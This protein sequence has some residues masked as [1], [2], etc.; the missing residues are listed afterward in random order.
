MGKIQ[1]PKMYPFLLGTPP[2]SI[3]VSQ[4]MGSLLPNAVLLASAVSAQ[5]TFLTNRHRPTDMYRKPVKVYFEVGKNYGETG[6]PCAHLTIN[7]IINQ[8]LL[9][10]SLTW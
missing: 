2:T 5:L 9:T 7:L 1:P 10:N 4:V 3:S 8:P 6:T